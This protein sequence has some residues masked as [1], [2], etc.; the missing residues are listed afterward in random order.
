MKLLYPILT[1]ST[2]DVSA[3]RKDRFYIDYN[4]VF[5]DYQ[6]LY[7]V[8]GANFGNVKKTDDKNR[9]QDLEDKLEYESYFTSRGWDPKNYQVRYL[10]NSDVD[11]TSIASMTCMTWLNKKFLL[12]TK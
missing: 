6:R 9:C 2:I 5:T 4:D 10:D 3:K 7:P 8:N 12:F 1:I 11:Q